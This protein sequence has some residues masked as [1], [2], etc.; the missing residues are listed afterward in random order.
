MTDV[1]K[2]ITDNID[3]WTSAIKKRNSQGRGSN[4]KIELIGV[5]KLRELILELAVRGK[6]VPQDVNDEPASVLLEKIAVEKAQLIA[7]KKIK[8]QKALSEITLEEKLFELPIGWKWC[9]LQDSIDVRDGTHDSPKDAISGKVFPLVTSKDFKNGEINF[10]SAR[11]ISAEDHFEISKRSLVEVGDILFSM[12]GGNIG[13]QV[14]VKDNRE[15]S[16]KNV[17]LFKY[18]DKSATVPSYFKI[19][20]ENLASVL[21]ES[22]KGGAQPFISLGALRKLVFA[23]PPLAEQQRIVAKV[24]ELM[25]LCDQLEQQTEQ[26]LNAHQTLVEVLLAALTNCD[27]TDDFQTS[28]QRI[29]E[30]F[31]VLFTTEHSIEQLKQTILQLAVM[32]KLVSQNPSDEPASVLLEKIAEEKSQHIAD[33]KIKKQKPL[34]AITDEEKPFELPSGWEFERLGNLTSRLGSGSTPR[35]GQSA[36]VDKGIIFLRSQNVWNDGLKLDDTAYI[37]DETHNKM[38][39]THVFPNDVLLN[40]TGASL[41]RSTI[42][43]EKLTTANVSQHVTIIRLLEERMC[44]FVH[45]GIM[46]PLVQKL[47]WGRQVGMAIEGLSKKVLEQFEFP[48]PPLAEQH[49]IVAKVDELMAL[50]EQLKTRL[51][52][53]QTTQLHLADAVVENA[54]N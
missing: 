6:L 53:A 38:E 3:L 23:L 52:D 49:R 31:D 15:F 22:A 48:V 24:D 35:G 39:N 8:K 7:N 9:R 41:G 25:A 51:S 20:T 36:Y 40:I 29:A 10:E 1:N 21:Q 5:K 16:I 42:F 50:C 14:I 54:L 30:Y 47:V 18:Y 37:S 17:A 33:K 27:S 32:G 11:R 34:P 13:N 43:P 28:W 26:S 44:E 4:K 12:I 2:L 46:S 45:L 19:Y